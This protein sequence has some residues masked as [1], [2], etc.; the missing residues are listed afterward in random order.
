MA[1][2]FLLAGLLLAAAVSWQPVTD[3]MPTGGYIQLLDKSFVSVEELLSAKEVT[4]VGYNQ[5][6]TTYSDSFLFVRDTIHNALILKGKQPLLLQK[7]FRC[8]TQGN[9]YLVHCFLQPIP[10]IDAGNVFYWCEP[11][12][13]IFF[14]SR[15]WPSYGLVQHA[16]HQ[17][18][19]RLIWSLAKAVYPPLAD[20][21]RIYYSGSI[22][23]GQEYQIVDRWDFVRLDA[24]RQ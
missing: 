4:S 21:C 12:G 23:H 16:Q 14:R 24:R 15:Y 9:T 7:T 18:E 11:F 8:Q 6:L 13:L 1:R 2:L 5:T 3:R 10:A 22:K 17:T 20:D 19:N